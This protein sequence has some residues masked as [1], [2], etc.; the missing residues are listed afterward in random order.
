MRWKLSV[1][2]VPAVVALAVLLS[3]PVSADLSGKWRIEDS[4]G[5]VHSSSM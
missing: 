4:L 2:P 5:N 1:V 3:A